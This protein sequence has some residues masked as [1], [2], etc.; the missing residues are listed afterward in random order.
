[1]SWDVVLFSSG[2]KITSIEDLDETKLIPIDFCA[3]FKH[4]FKHV[5]ENGNHC[6][7]K[8][9]DFCIE[10]FTDSIVVSNKIVS[11]YGE[12]GL[13]ELVILSK[14]LGWQI[15]DTSLG[16]MIDLDNP[17]SNGYEKFQSYLRHV[18]KDDH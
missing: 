9:V 11:L 14:K 7:V 1:M 10:Y 16:D 17:G 12:N 4:H 6:T 3:E 13:Y 15:F 5:I 8:G 2:E 18:L